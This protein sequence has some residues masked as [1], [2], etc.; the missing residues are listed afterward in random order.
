MVSA[1]PL[2]RLLSA[3][4]A[5]CGGATVM[6][7]VLAAWAVLL[8]CASRASAVWAV[9]V[10][11]TPPFP[12]GPHSL[13]SPAGQTPPRASSRACLPALPCVTCPRP[14]L[15]Q[16]TYQGGLRTLPIRQIRG[17]RHGSGEQYPT[18]GLAFRSRSTTPPTARIKA[19]EQLGTGPASRGTQLGG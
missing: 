14:P 5:E 1:L 10:L 18:P 6:R 3:V 13:Y 12:G 15:M 19:N 16:R 11:K 17:E 2:A 8:L 9:V 7:G 4:C